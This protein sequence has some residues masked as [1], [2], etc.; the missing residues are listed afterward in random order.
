MRMTLAG[1]G[2]RVHAVLSGPL[3]TDMTSQLP[4]TKT[5]PNEAARAIFDGVAAGTE[6][7]FPDPWSAAALAETW[8]TGPAK[9]LE[10]ENAAL[11]QPMG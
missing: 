3:D 1:Q 2:V 7:I 9:R 4:F 10:R 11:P 5:P 8:P 6:D